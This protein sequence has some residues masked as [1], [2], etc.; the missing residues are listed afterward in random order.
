MED[1]S[2]AGVG[3]AGAADVEIMTL[4]P[5]MRRV[6]LRG[7]LTVG[8]A[9]R[10]A[11]G[12]AAQ[13]IDIVRGWARDRGEAQWD[14][15]LDLELPPSTGLT[16]A[17]VLQLT[18]PDLAPLREA[19]AGPELLGHRLRWSGPDVVVE[20]E[21]ADGRGFLDRTLR[22][23]AFFGLF[24]REMQIETSDGLVHDVFRLRSMHAGAPEPAT[25]EALAS[26][27]R[28]ITLP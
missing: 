21:A 28:R 8:W 1:D 18:G 13:R 27:L 4:G 15:Q 14:A 2:V 6:S 10:L 17:L 12:L 20:I 5:T 11:S 19:L 9:G 25:V 3:P 7:S 23:F 16:P 26:R 22:L 24:P